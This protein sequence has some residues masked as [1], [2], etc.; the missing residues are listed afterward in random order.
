MAWAEDYRQDWIAETIRV[1]GFINREHLERKFG[2]STPQASLDLQRFMRERP[3]LMTYDK[4]AK[5]Y[6]GE[7]MSYVDNA[8]MGQEIDAILAR[9]E[10][11]GPKLHAG[12]DALLARLRRPPV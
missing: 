7:V 12:A 3:G 11:E 8:Q 2:I 5:R 9:L 4:S 1:F 10:R 6:V